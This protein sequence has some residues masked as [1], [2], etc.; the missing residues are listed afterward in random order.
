MRI[1]IAVV[2]LAGCTDT[3]LDEDTTYRRLRDQFSSQDQCLAEGDFTPCYQTLVLCANGRARID[4]ENSPQRG[5]YQLQGNVAVA[6]FTTMGT[7][8]FDLE[9]I[10][11]DDLPGRHPWDQIEPLFQSCD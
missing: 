5:T 8:D 11:S 1:A 10:T 7:I 6:R 4:L 3:V 2:L 9:A